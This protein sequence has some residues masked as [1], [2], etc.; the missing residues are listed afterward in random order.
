MQG[1]FDVVLERD[2]EGYYVASVPQLPGC[3][4]QEFVGIRRITIAARAGRRVLRVP[5]SSQHSPGGDLRET[6]INYVNAAR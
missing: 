4:T 3:N 5:N 1:Q 6:A 2:E